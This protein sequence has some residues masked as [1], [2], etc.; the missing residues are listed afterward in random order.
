MM[1]RK[2]LI[3]GGL[4]VLLFCSFGFMVRA[5]GSPSRGQGVKG[6][7]E[8]FGKR[9]LYSCEYGF[10]Y[11]GKKSGA[12]R[13]KKVLQTVVKDLR[14]DGVTE[15]TDGLILVMDSKEKPPIEFT[16]L[17]QA[18]KKAEAQK[19]GEN[20]QDALKV[21]TEVKEKMEKE[22]LEMDVVLSIAPIPI[23]RAA[24]PEILKEFP[25]DV[26]AQIGW[27][28]IV[29]TDRCV[30]AG[31]KKI[32]DAGM[33]KEKAGL[34]QR[35]MVGALMPFIEHKAVQQIKKAWQAMLYELVLDAE[36]DLP[37]E[38]KQQMCKAYK[39]KLGVDDES[40]GD[41]DEQHNEGTEENSD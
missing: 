35:L 6:W 28:L 7:P 20:S 23:G 37:D 2:S 17:V 39:Q 30:R 15:L 38:Q 10:I 29:P 4:A 18:V 5:E 3:A 8:Q 25:E 9:K 13:A 11:A 19:E 32:I 40:K 24:L 1:K 21:L 22:G 16:T 27:C 31:I 12:E 26:N 41:D 34:A 36:E 14:Q 33:K